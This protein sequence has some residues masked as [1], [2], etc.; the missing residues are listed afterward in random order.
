M[1]YRV[2]QV[3]LEII[4][5]LILLLY[6][7]KHLGLNQALVAAMSSPAPIPTKKRMSR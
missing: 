4:L 5:P 1:R 6:L 3:S 7:R 2:E